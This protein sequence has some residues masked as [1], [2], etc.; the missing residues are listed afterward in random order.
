MVLLKC[1]TQYVNKFGKL[2]NGRRTGKGQFSFQSQRKAVPKNSQTIVQLCSSHTLAR[3]CSKSFKSG[4]S[5][6]WTK[7]F[8]MYKLDLEKAEESEIKLP[9]FVGS[10][11]KQR[12][13]RK[14]FISASLTMLKPLTVW[15]RTNCGKFWKKW[16]Y[17]TTWPVSW[18][19]CI[20]GQ[21]TSVRTRHGTSSTLERRM[22]RLYI[23]T[24]LI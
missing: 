21:E 4:F 14:T 12:N 20:V 22:S 19:T 16:E 1:C 9:T 24:L 6:M 15:I 7:N 8:Q 5:N 17:Q 3:S 11:R 13:S 18:E 2:S 23:V 10:Q